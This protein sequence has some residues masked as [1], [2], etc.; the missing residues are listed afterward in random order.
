MRSRLADEKSSSRVQDLASSAN[1]ALGQ[2]YE[3]LRA[4][5]RDTYADHALGLLALSL[6]GLDSLLGCL[7]EGSWA[8]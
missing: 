4:D 1:V 7:S 6:R 5:V 2:Q 8:L 3:I